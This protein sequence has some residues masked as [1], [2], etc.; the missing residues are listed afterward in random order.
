VSDPSV[1]I[2]LLPVEPE[3]DWAVWLTGSASGLTATLMMRMRE[4]GG[5]LTFN[6]HYARDDSPVREQLAV[7]EF[8]RALEP[9]GQL[10]LTDIG[11]TSRPPFAIPI[12][13]PQDGHRLDQLAAFFRDVVAIEDWADVRFE[14]PSDIL[15]EDARTVAAASEDIMRG[16][17][18]GILNEFEVTATKAGVENLRGSPPLAVEQQWRA[19]LFGQVIDL[20]YTHI[21]FIDYEVVSAEP[22]DGTDDEFL[23]RIE[24]KTSEG[25]SVHATLSKTPLTSVPGDENADAA[26]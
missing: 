12:S 6:L 26:E 2:Y 14:L 7:I 1:D 3:G 21:V 25:A 20:G 4:T 17:Y 11:N 24:P 18:D 23:V 9:A 15:I 10:L 19:R 13:Q 5:Q 8:L 22:V 16:G